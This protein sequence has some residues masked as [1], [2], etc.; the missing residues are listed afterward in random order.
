MA[1]SQEV[2]RRGTTTLLDRRKVSEVNSYN[3]RSETT[4]AA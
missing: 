4:N 1:R 3:T 2:S